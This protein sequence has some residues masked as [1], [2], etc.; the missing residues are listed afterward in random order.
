MAKISWRC[1]EDENGDEQLEKASRL[2]SS[3]NSYFY[4]EVIRQI[5]KDPTKTAM[6][7]WEPVSTEECK[8]LIALDEEA[9]EKDIKQAR[10]FIQQT[11]R[12]VSVLRQV[13]A[14]SSDSTWRY[15]NP[16]QLCSP[17]ASAL[18][19]TKLTL[20]SVQSHPHIPQCGT[21]YP[22]NRG[23]FSSLEV[24]DLTLPRSFTLVWTLRKSQ[25]QLI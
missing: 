12:R 2:A 25:R 16:A 10:D 24:L 15:C 1:G 20:Q 13:A 17:Y 8:Q 3:M 5:D 18:V 4:K 21:Q 6:R 11:C 9:E 19:Y 22:P 14:P 7:H 23:N